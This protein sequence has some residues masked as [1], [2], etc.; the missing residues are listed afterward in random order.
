MKSLRL[1]ALAWIG[2]ALAWA[3]ATAETAPPPKPAIWLLAD[4]DTK[5]YLFGTTHILP[6]DFVWRSEA[7]ERVV[8]EADELVMETADEKKVLANPEMLLSAMMLDKPQPIL[9]RVSEGRRAKL[10]SMI[11]ESGGAIELYDR[12]HTWA[13]AFLLGVA[14]LEMAYG[15][16]GRDEPLTGV[17]DELTSSFEQAGKPIAGLETT[18]QQLAFFSEVSPA[19]QKE[20]LESTIDE[21]EDV[22][23]VGAD[24]AAWARGDVEALA[25]SIEQGLSKEMFEILITRRNA[26]WTEWLA[27]RLDRPGTLLFAVGAGH[28]AGD[29]SVQAMLASRGLAVERID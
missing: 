10:R 17:E 29:S 27:E 11:K 28:L 1:L 12:F 19:G 18:M 3:P 7:L 9:R 21:A 4:E 16:D 26:A 15:A 6:R 5:I 13:A 14:Q 23:A 24:D 8:A 20:L 25:Q 22:A 2:A